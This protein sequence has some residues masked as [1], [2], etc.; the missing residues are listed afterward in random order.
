VAK[1]DRLHVERGKPLTYLAHCRRAGRKP[2]RQD[3]FYRVLIFSD[4]RELRE[5]CRIYCA[6]AVIEKPKVRIRF[7]PKSYGRRS[8]WANCFGWCCRYA[9]GFEI[10]RRPGQVG[11][12]CLSAKSTGGTI[13]SHEFAH[14]ALYQ[15]TVGTLKT[16]PGDD[17]RLAWML[18]EFVGEFYTWFYRTLAKQRRRK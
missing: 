15:V 18:G 9:E 3:P 17:E 14:A 2:S 8:H 10:G 16:L 1:T 5:F 4:V 11:L 13:V 12:I 6:Q 7:F